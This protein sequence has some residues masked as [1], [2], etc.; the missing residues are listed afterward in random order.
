MASFGLI[1]VSFGIG[2]SINKSSVTVGNLPNENEQITEAEV[3][4]TPTPTPTV[5]ITATPTPTVT[6]TPT[7]TFT[8]QQANTPRPGRGMWVLSV[9]SGSEADIGGIRAGQILI[10]LN[11]TYIDQVETANWI[12]SQNVNRTIT[13]LVWE[14]GQQKS[15]N[16]IP[17]DNLIGVNLCQLQLCPNGREP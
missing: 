17:R 13:A 1:I 9:K 3:I 4:E 6:I 10:S 12:V 2:F 11:G 7:P 8:P 14:N 16:V 15:L 5:T